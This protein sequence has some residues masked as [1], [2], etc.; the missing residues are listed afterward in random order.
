MTSPDALAARLLDSGRLRHP[1][2]ADAFRAVPR[3]RFVPLTGARTD[4]GAPLDATTDHA[5]WLAAVYSDEPIITQTDDGDPAVRRGMSSSSCSAP[6]VVAR[7]LEAAD[8][9]DLP[10]SG[11]VLEIG[12]GTGWNAAL[13]SEI[14]GSGRVTSVDVD[15]AVINHARG[16]LAR[17]G[18]APTVH[19]FDGEDGF[20]SRAPY[21]RIIATCTVSC[22]PRAWRE[23]TAPGGVI[24][25]PWA[26]MD[27]PVGVLARLRIGGDGTATGEF[28]GGVA[29][30]WLRAQRPPMV[31][32]HDLGRDAEET[33]H[34]EHDP[35]SVLFEGAAAFGLSVRVP[36]WRYGMRPGEHGLTVWLSA[37]DGPSWARVVP[38]AGGWRIDQGGPR[39]LWTEIEVAL[40]EWHDH[41]RPGSDRQA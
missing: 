10:P 7:M 15:P 2:L 18:Y 30:M 32:P 23:Q 41:G 3:E 14:L 16:A 9:I 29:F 5:G 24:L 25:T 27:G 17:S 28:L 37:T 26:A 35:T 8:L 38:E 21:A 31:R 22:V 19:V 39:R 6:G 1:A 12:T 11:T 33:R 13:L 4:N 40:A 36:R 34:V 20:P